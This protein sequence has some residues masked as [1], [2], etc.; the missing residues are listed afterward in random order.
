MTNAADLIPRNKHDFER[1]N[2]LIAAGPEAAVPHLEV[3]L[4]WIQDINWPIAAPLAEFLVTVGEP[5]VPHLKKILSSN[6]EMWIYWV[7]Q[8]VVAKLPPEL[9]KN[10][11]WQLHNLATASENDFVATKIAASAALWDRPQLM[12][13]IENKI[14][15]YESFVA[16]LKELRKSLE[17]E[18]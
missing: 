15:A 18:K 11:D 1:L 13:I 10:F 12:R 16:E 5:L 2:A 4:T 14:R 8:F 17:E 3:L 7:L 9:I 6:D